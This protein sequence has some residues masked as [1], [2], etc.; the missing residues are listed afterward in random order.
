M[1]KYHIGMIMGVF[2]MF[3]IGHLRLIRNAREHC[4]YL[5]AC[6][7]SDDLVFRFKQHYPVIPL[8]ER[9]EIIGAVKGVDEVAAIMD[10]P[11]R[12]LEYSRRPFDCFFSG[13]DYAGNEY[14]EMERRELK[15]LGA[16]IMF[17]PHTKEQS[18]TLIRRKAGK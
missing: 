2:D 12:L 13:D 14:W 16:D 5:R 9:M 18:T 4:D 1:E 7:L 11:S 3:H 15:K 6:V 8:A 10:D 17:F